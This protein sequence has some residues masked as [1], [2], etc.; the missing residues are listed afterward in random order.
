VSA[1]WGDLNARARGLAT[2]LASGPALASLAA[3]ADLPAL[4]RALVTYGILP[5][6]PETSTPRDFELAI[7]RGSAARLGRLIRW[8][9]PRTALLGI[10][11]DDEDRRSLRA[12][13]RGGAAGA[14]AELR[15]AGLLPTPTLPERL[16]AELARQPRPEEV[17]ALLVAW[18]HPYGPPLQAIAAGDPP[19]LYRLEC[20]LNRTFAE[21]ASAGARRGGAA[22][23]AHVRGVVDLENLTGGLVLA[24]SEVEGPVAE[25]FLPGGRQLPLDRY[26]AAIA[27]RDPDRA[28][29]LLSAGFPERIGA[30]A[31]REARHPIALEAGL[32]RE[33][34]RVLSAAARL[35][36]LGPA[37]LLCYLLRLRAEA[38]TLRRLVWA[39]ASGMPPALRLDPME[40][41]A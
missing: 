13:L 1:A 40:A 33:R 24:G 39:T 6:E 32:L 34:I 20:A 31:R 17:A 21:R 8:M 7:R 10:V 5:T 16:L 22:L 23:R 15:L 41:P 12:I 2:H 37:P 27:T 30:L 35:D 14:A 18:G 3:A 36:P 38:G 4:G 25:A 19:D 11:L 9:G 29:A 28:V 26:L